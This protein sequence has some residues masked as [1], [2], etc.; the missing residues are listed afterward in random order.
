M[1]LHLLNGISIAYNV[2]ISRSDDI[3]NCL[4]TTWC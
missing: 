3:Y 1:D 2:A 4:E